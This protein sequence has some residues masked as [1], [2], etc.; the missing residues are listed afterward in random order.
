MT[1]PARMP[2]EESGRVTRKEGPC[3][4][5]PEVARRLDHP[6]IDAVERGEEGQDQERH[7][8]VDESK[9][10]GLVL[11]D[12]PLPGRIEDAHEH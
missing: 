10:D 5:G 1:H 7:V 9:D 6:R 8:T 2:C 4:A 11:A 12:Q 3:R